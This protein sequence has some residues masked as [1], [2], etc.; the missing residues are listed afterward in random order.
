LRIK[1]TPDPFTSPHACLNISAGAT[2]IEN[3]NAAYYANVLNDGAEPIAMSPINS[4]PVWIFANRGDGGLHTPFKIGVQATDSG[5]G[6]E[7]GNG[8]KIIANNSFAMRDVANN[9]VN[10][11]QLFQDGHSGVGAAN[12]VVKGYQGVEPTPEGADGWFSYNTR[13]DDYTITADRVNVWDNGIIHMMNKTGNTN[14]P[15]MKWNNTLFD[16]AHPTAPT[17]PNPLSIDDDGDGIDWRNYTF[18]YSAGGGTDP[19]PTGI[20]G[21]LNSAI[22]TKSVYVRG[23]TDL[24]GDEEG[25]PVALV[26]LPIGCFALRGAE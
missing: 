4:G 19:F 2:G 21:G 14:R 20:A 26:D 5:Y 22:T 17:L 13:A 25:D 1:K 23:I 16:P 15:R 10:M 6:A 11:T 8:Y 9:E 12:N 7:N 3:I 18:S 24:A